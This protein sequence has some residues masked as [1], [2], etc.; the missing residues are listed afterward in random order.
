M[1]LL[2]Y[3][4]GGVI[5]FVAARQGPHWVLS[6]GS[7]RT[8]RIRLIAAA[9]TVSYGLTVPVIIAVADGSS[10]PAWSIAAA[11]VSGSVLHTAGL[12]SWAGSSPWL[13]RL[14]G[15]MLMMGAAVV[16]SHVTLLIPAVAVLAGTLSRVQQGSPAAAR[17]S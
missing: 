8:A 2:A 9:I 17:N 15:W 5:A 1:V 16:P 7:E 13:M 4:L 11:A 3:S 12:V 14:V 10:L 6:A